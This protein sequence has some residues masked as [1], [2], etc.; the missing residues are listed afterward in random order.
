[1]KDAFGVERGEI[2]KA[3]ASLS[4][5]DKAGIVAA[6]TGAGAYLGHKAYMGPDHWY[7]ENIHKPWFN[8]HLQE[9]LRT[10]SK[11]EVKSA[12]Q[13]IDDARKQGEATAAGQRKQAQKL[14]DRA[15]RAPKQMRPDFFEQQARDRAKADFLDEK[16]SS[17]STPDAMKQQVSDA[18]KIISDSKRQSRTKPR[19][20]KKQA[21]R[22]I[23]RTE[24]P[25]KKHQKAYKYNP[26]LP[27]ARKNPK[28][29]KNLKSTNWHKSKDFFRDFPKDLPGAGYRRAGGWY[30]KGKT[31]HAVAIG[32]MAVGA[33]LGYAGTRKLVSK[34]PN[35]KDVSKGFNAKAITRHF[36]YVPQD[37]V[38]LKNWHRVIRDPGFV[39][40]AV[41]I[42][43]ASVVGL[44]AA[45]HHQ[46]KKGKKVHL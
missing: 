1:M 34:V 20:T 6:G 2:S 19:M 30:S 28:N 12:T 11:K 46:K 36:K 33:G 17:P 18:Q 22:F 38:T 31:G 39:T 9:A 26:N 4:D 21:Q 35:D 14:R 42:P 5:K 23:E 7:N 10:P 43:T 29:V 8:H 13:T 41:T 3:T 40:P 45:K 25:D 37:E 24:V 16:A 44:A 32:T 15:V 27:N